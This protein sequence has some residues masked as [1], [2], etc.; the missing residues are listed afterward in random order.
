[1]RATIGALPLILLA[2]CGQ[3]R[4]MEPQDGWWADAGDYDVQETIAFTDVPYDF[5]GATP[6]ADLPL[7][8]DF[9]TEWAAGDAALPECPDWSVSDE[10]PVEITGIVTIYPRYYFKTDGCDGDE[11]KFYGSYFIQDA[12]GGHFVL[13]DTKVAHFDAGDRVTLKVR[14]IANRFDL[15]M[16]V[17]HDVV[18]VDVGPEPIFY[19]VADGPL[20]TDD[21][22]LV[23]RVT[24]TVS[25]E[26]DT[27]GAFTVTGDDG[28]DWNVGLDVELNRR[29]V[30]YAPGTRVT[31]TGPVQYS[32]SL[33]TIV[34]MQKGQ[35]Q[36]LDDSSGE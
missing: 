29:G 34:V 17:G 7:P 10:L 19:E 11:E 26:M 27:F 15:P 14:G 5:T 6:I 3:P 8:P 25:T 21:I 2:G 33:F 9:A 22:A 32:F 36:I 16:I 24:G 30:E 31:V 28:T 20:T 23:R 35:I 13:G 12:S 4:G 1:M 18:D